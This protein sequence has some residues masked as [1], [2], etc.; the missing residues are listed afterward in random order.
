MK[1]FKQ[2]INH[3]SKHATTWRISRIE[4]IRTTGRKFHLN[5]RQT[6]FINFSKIAKLHQRGGSPLG[7]SRVKMSNNEDCVRRGLVKDGEDPH[8][9]AARQ[10]IKDNIQVRLFYC[11]Q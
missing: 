7:N 2:V 8:D 10:L 11:I 3:L 9:I 5:S 6:Y 4:K 1:T